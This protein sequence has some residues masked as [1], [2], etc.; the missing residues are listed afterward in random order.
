MGRLQVG[1][2]VC[3][4][5]RR[6]GRELEGVVLSRVDVRKHAGYGYID[7]GYYHDERYTKYYD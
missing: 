1:G 7:S 3:R 5:P 4:P 6:R 2:S